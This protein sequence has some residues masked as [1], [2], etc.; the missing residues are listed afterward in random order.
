MAALV[1]IDA[2]LQNSQV[3]APIPLLLIL[4]PSRPVFE[5][6]VMPGGSRAVEA[7]KEL[8]SDVEGQTG[9]GGYQDSWRIESPQLQGELWNGRTM[10]QWGEPRAEGDYGRDV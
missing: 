7:E 1:Q 5:W 2:L 4:P 3:L 10:N 9:S 8:S 6:R